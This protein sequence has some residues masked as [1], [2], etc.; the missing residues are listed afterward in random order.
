MSACDRVGDGGPMRNT[1]DRSK[2]KQMKDRRLRRRSIIVRKIC[3]HSSMQNHRSIYNS[4]MYNHEAHKHTK[5]ISFPFRSSPPPPPPPPFISHDAKYK[6]LSLFPLI[7]DPLFLPVPLLP[8][9]ATLPS[10]SPLCPIMDF[11]CDV[12]KEYLLPE[13]I[14]CFN[15][16]EQR[17]KREEKEG[18]GD[19]EECAQSPLA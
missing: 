7:L 17:A 13:C 15:G 8:P 2:P 4:S 14:D 3:P 12:R 6:P 5:Q 18:T 19:I 9:Y 11:S 10:F 16:R 1:L